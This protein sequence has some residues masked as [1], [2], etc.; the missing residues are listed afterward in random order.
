VGWVFAQAISDAVGG[1]SRIPVTAQPGGRGVMTLPG[2]AD[3][4]KSVVNADSPWR[5]AVWAGPIPT[6]AF[7]RPVTKARRL[8]CPVLVQL[9]ERDISAPCR[10]IEKLAE[11]APQA[12]LKRYDLDHFQPFYGEH[13][14][15]LASDQADW[16]KRTV[17]GVD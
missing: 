7:Y 3:G 6:V 16:L 8:A 10:A 12:E 17:L 14:A 1:K 15:R 9:G 2:E 13:P 5:N 11:R 4:F